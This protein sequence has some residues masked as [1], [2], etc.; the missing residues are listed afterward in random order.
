MLAPKIHANKV[1]WIHICGE[2]GVTKSSDY[3]FRIGRDGLIQIL[4]ISLL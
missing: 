4:A 1:N 3:R 2:Y